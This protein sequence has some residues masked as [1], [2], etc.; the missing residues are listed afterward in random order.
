MKLERINRVT[1]VESVTERLVSLITEGHIKHGERLPSEA[2]L[3]EQLQVGR[4]SVR[5]A[6]RGLALVG[7]VESRPRRGTIVVSPTATSLGRNL[8]KSL[9]YWALKD[10]F[11]VRVLLEGH[12]AAT[13][14][15]VA[16][17]TEIKTIEATAEAVERRIAA[18]QSYFAENAEFHL[19]VAGASHN[20]VLTNC[21]TSII[22]SLRDVRERMNVMRS[23]M[24]KR[25]AEDHRQIIEAIRARN[26]TKARKLME[27]HLNR[28]IQSLEPA[29][30]AKAP[31]QAASRRGERA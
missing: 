7:I 16:T 24:P 1:V 19:K 28:T 27:A 26:A 31:P 23:E 18:N 13:A 4:S 22:G 17:K 25:D 21:L 2:E 15:Q 12:A 10:L 29:K 9:T 8:Q 30:P 3:M 5:E 6:L 20:P 11:E 14:A